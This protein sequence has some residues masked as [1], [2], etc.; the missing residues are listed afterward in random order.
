MSF[1][2]SVMIVLFLIVFLHCRIILR[3]CQNE[4]ES[5]ERDINN[6]EALLNN[7]KLIDRVFSHLNKRKERKLTNE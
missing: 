6:I 7:T 5:F 2:L 1:E 4:S 3:V